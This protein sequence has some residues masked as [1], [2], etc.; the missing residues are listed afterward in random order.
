V[1]I[2]T[3]PHWHA[4]QCI[5]AAQAGKDIFCEK[6]MTKFIAEGRAVAEAVKRY[7]VIEAGGTNDPA[8]LQ[9]AEIKSLKGDN[10]RGQLRFIQ[11]IPKE[12]IL[13]WLIGMM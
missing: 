11:I 4:I 5:M 7:G 13:P 3:P 2:S 8:D 12:R 9:E 1:C 10:Y 6:P